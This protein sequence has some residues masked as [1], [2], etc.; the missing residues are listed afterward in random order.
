MNTKTKRSI[1]VVGLFSFL[2][3]VTIVFAQNR[4][5]IKASRNYITKEIKIGNFDKINLLGSPTV[6]Y[7]QSTNG[8]SEL[9][10]YG[11]DN[12]LDELE[13]DVDGNT[14]VVKYKNGVNIQFG[15]EGRLKIMASSPSLKDVHL[16]GSGDVILSNKVK[17][18]DL[19][20]NL[21]GSGDIQAGEIV[22]SNNFSATLQGSGDIHVENTLQTTNAVL[23]LQGSGDLSVA[24]LTAKSA[25]ATLQGSGD[26]NVKGTR[27]NGEVTI[28]LLGSGD[29]GFVGISAERVNAELQGS[30]DMKL[31]GTTQQATLVL[32]NSGDLD[33]RSL[34]ATQVDA[35]LNGSGDIS[36]SVSG[37]LKCSINGSGDISYKGNPTHVESSGKSKPRRL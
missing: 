30:G 35:N 11:S 16:Q 31:A 6:V 13:C 5:T 37:N 18:T 32:L 7:T 20:L 23:S 8:R 34:N 3:C 21:Q 15:K 14:L 2:C 29:L 27:V 19:V 17:C 26:L 1:A 28:K 12:I 22:C 33:A 25:S 36:C 24:N 9:K 4:Q 10:L